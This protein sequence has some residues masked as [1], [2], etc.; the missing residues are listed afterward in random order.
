MGVVNT[1]LLPEL[2][3]RGWWDRSYSRLCAFYFDV[4]DAPTLPLLYGEEIT[5]EQKENILHAAEVGR[6]D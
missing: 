3:H 1:C 2:A 4:E 6:A 5:D